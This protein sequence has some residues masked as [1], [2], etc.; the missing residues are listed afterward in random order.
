MCVM[1][2]NDLQISVIHW[3]LVTT[4]LELATFCSD[5]SRTPIQG[6]PLQNMLCVFVCVN[7]KSQEV[8]WNYIMTFKVSHISLTKQSEKIPYPCV[9]AQQGRYQWVGMDN[10][11]WEHSH[12]WSRTVVQPTTG[13]IYRSFWYKACYSCPVMILA[14]E[15]VSRGSRV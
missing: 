11:V 6:A 10:P 8:W 1:V 12:G 14:I 3:L 13:L 7:G 2:P 9:D 5:Y 4:F 15:S